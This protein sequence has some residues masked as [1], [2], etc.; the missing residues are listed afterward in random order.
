MMMKFLEK[1]AFLAMVAVFLLVFAS[2]DDDEGDSSTPIVLGSSVTVTNTLESD[3]ITGGTETTIEML[4]GLG[5][6]ALA[7]NATVTDAVEFSNYLLG[8][9]DIDIDENEISFE[10]VASADDSTYMDFF[11]TLEAG[12]TDRYYFTFDK[13]QNVTGSTSSDASVN[14]RVDADTVLVVEIGE[15]FSFNP[16]SSFTINLED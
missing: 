9:Y 15:G 12:T 14:L 6:G 2:C 1:N 7:S 11:R 3:M 13:A 16:G 8:L 10:L 5:E 4:F